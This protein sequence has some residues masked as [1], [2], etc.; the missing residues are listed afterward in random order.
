M[1]KLYYKRKSLRLRVNEDFLRHKST[2]DEIKLINGL[3]KKIKIFYSLKG[4]IK[5]IKK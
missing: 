1:L 5:K 2:N 3:W 4:I